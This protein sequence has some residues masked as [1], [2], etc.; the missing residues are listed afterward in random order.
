LIIDRVRSIAI[1]DSNSDF[2]DICEI[3][4]KKGYGPITPPYFND[5]RIIQCLTVFTPISVGLSH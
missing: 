5:P 4:P 1:Q 3:R 2:K